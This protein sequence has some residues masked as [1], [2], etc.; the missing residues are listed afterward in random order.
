MLSIHKILDY[1][2]DYVD[3]KKYSFC[4]FHS[5]VFL[6]F[7]NDGCLF[8]ILLP[9]HAI[10][11]FVSL[12]CWMKACFL[13]FYFLGL[14]W[15]DVQEERKYLPLLA[16]IK[17]MRF[18]TGGD[19]TKIRK[20]R[21]NKWEALIMWRCNHVNEMLF[22]IDLLL[23][24]DFLNLLVSLISYLFEVLKIICETFF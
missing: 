7:T 18:P 3:L 4:F 1:C 23:L 6:Y 17:W 15:Q 20:I 19:L 22:D 8:L 5:S 14:S 24:L 9:I 21:K 16:K 12:L 2:Y 13:W 11:N 10:D